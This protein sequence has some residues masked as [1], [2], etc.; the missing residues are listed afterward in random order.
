MRLANVHGRAVLVTGDDS[1]IDV[2]AASDGRFGPGLPAVFDDWDAFRPWARALDPVVGELRFDRAELGPPSPAP[3][4][5]FAIGLNYGAHAAES[6]FDAPQGMPP[7]FTKFVSSLTG[8]D[9]V[10]EIPQDGHVD[11]E[12]ELVVVIGREA[13]GVSAE[14]AWDHVAGVTVGQDISERIS[15]LAGPAPQFS[16]GK[17][18]PGF[19]P[20]GPWLVTADELPARDDLA[21]G[22]RIGDEPVQDGRTGRMLYSVPELIE[23]LSAVLPLLPGDIV[24]T[25]TPEGVGIGRKPARFLEAGE[26]LTSWIEGVGEIRQSFAPARSVAVEGDRAVAIGVPA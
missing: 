18:F 25:G 22:A 9:S 13:R 6:P 26:T 7:V 21:L 19:A 20:T 24:F 1:G 23:A 12:V 17:S 15:Q 5:V 16:L 14:R 4:Q 3:R 10:V 2:G 8:P 11:W